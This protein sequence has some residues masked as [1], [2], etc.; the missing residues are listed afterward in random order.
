MA[1]A[2]ADGTED[3]E[4]RREG[5]NR[6]R[7]A[8]I[9]CLVLAVIA[10]AGGSAAEA[11]INIEFRPASQA[12]VVGDTVNVGLYVVSDSDEDQLL[13]AAQVIL[14]WDPQF[15][16]LLGNDDTGAVPLLSSGF[17][18]NDPFNLNEQVPPQD[19]DGLYVAFAPLG[20]PVAATP[21]GTLLTTFQF[22]AL[23]E[24]PKTP[25]DILETGGDPQGETI[26]FDGTIP[27]LDVTG[28]LTGAV[29]Q[30]VAASDAVRLTLHVV[31]QLPV[32]EGD[33]V[34]IALTML[35]L[36]DNEAAGFQAFLE[37]GL[38]E[39]AFVGGEY[40]EEPFGLP[41]I[42]PIIAVGEHIDLAAGID[43]RGGQEP[44][45]KDA[46]LALLTFVA[47]EAGCVSSLQ[48][49]DHDPP[50]RLTDEFGA[51]IEP[52][53]LA[54]MLPEPRTGDLD[55]DGEVGVSDLLILLA[56]W[57][58]CPTDDQCPADLN[59]DGMVG[60]ADLLT[61]LANWGPV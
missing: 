21:K 49:R 8:A 1:C 34:V 17:P 43:V 37:F 51:S 48:F 57:G 18:A 52:L 12:V 29:V 9:L 61:L 32:D 19:G 56:G 33:L 6:W 3:E 30:I 40:T 28:T 22:L 13:A 5:R 2:V 59:C 27:N 39:L 44:T 38:G 11:A 10:I 58:P 4:M 23:A 35:D 14:G 15:L 45:S 24:T 55:F 42:D 26:V 54:G 16:Q 36:G 25:V 47:L 46:R 60:V 53:L 7:G 31:S 20:Q 50:T 41:I